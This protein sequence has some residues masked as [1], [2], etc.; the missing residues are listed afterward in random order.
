MYEAG[1]TVEQETL[2]F[3]PAHE[4]A[5]PL[6]SKEEAQDYR[7]LPEP[8]LVPIEPPA[9]LVERLRAEIPEPP[10]ARIRRFERDYGLPFY[11]A[12]VLNGS[13]A[14]A[15]LFEGVVAG[16]VEAKAA[17]NV[18][19][20]EF[21]RTGVDPASVDG[22]QL[23]K[24]LEARSRI[25]RDTFAEALGASGDPGFDAERYL[26][27]G[28]VADASELEPLV[29]RVLAANPSEVESYRGGK[30]GLFGFFVGQVMRESQGKADPKIVN[31]LLRQKLG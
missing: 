13:A 17:S 4:S 27:D 15:R 7:Y 28:L 10:G 19:M 24:L 18:L 1:G 20:N 9:E 5:P 29:E 3:D 6:R 30:Q 25:P 2:H 26:G 8:D 23:A 22:A 31:E 21:A 12:E 16:G 14:L 11:D